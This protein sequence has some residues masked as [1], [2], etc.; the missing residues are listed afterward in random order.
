MPPHDK[1]RLP[2][3]A[4]QAAAKTPKTDD[5]SSPCAAARRTEA[6]GNGMETTAAHLAV[7][8]SQDSV[9]DSQLAKVCSAVEEAAA[10]A[11]SGGTSSHRTLARR[12]S[13]S[14]GSHTPGDAS[15]S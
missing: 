2:A 10:R 7:A 5:A 11:A 14:G 13:A 15:V 6:D 9:S 1:K 4:S 12:P 8:F 3:A